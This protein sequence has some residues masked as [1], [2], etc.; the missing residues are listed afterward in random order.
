[1]SKVIKQVRARLGAKWAVALFL[2]PVAAFGVVRLGPRA[3]FVLALSVSICM[4]TSILVRAL[5]GQPWRL[6]NAGSIVTGMLLGLTLSADVPVYMILVGALVAEVVGK[7]RIDRLASNP[8]NPAA[9]GRAAI[10]V[11][12]L[13]D[14]PDYAALHVDGL[15]SAS[16]LL[17]NA[18]GNRAPE[19]WAIFVGNTPGAIGETSALLLGLSGL[20]LLA[21]VVVKREAAVAMLVTIAALTVMLPATAEIY[22]HAPWVL[23]PVVYLL[24]GPAFLYAFFFATDPATT[25]NTRWG[26]VIFGVGAGALGVLGRLYTTIPGAEMWAILIMNLAS[27]G[28]DRL[29]SRERELRKVPGGAQRAGC[30]TFY[31]QDDVGADA[32]AGMSDSLVL[33]GAEALVPSQLAPLEILR[34]ICLDPREDV[35]GRVEL[36]GLSGCGGAHFPAVRKWKTARATTGPRILI[37]NAQEGEPDSVKDRALMRQR[38]EL[39]VAGAGIVAHLIEAEEVL[40]VCGPEEVLGS[41]RLH[42]AIEELRREH[43]DLARRFKLVTGPGLYV[44]GEETA[45]IAFLEGERGEP[46]ERPPHPVESGLRGLPTVVHNAETLAWLPRLL[47][48]D[49][50]KLCDLP[51]LVTVSGDV[52]KPGVYA[53]SRDLSLVEL[54]A[55]AGGMVDGGE[56]MAYAIGGPTGEILDRDRGDMTVA[57]LPGTGTLRVLGAERCLV[58]EAL[59]ATHFA[60]AETCGRCT[61]C[62]VGS[63]EL[64][65][66]W[67]EVASGCADADVLVLID[68]LG[69]TMAETS[70]C[71]LGRDAP[72]R[73]FSV[74]RSFPDTV[75]S[76]LDGHECK[77]CKKSN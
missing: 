25:P 34:R 58:R 51:R 28:L 37:V 57:E 54:V 33:A 4:G 9:L 10:A 1:M 71:G 69:Q 73:V 66:L 48:E 12:E 18:G 11:I 13:L 29:L 42:G 2:V 45:L 74:L 70:A 59:R 16:P 8:F 43:P 55:R 68:E 31:D 52:R 50:P 21:F 65:R 20:L 32:G 56:A 44:C 67:S 41:A 27:P 6:L 15:S 14:P 53:A 60:A 77:A 3:G 62:R 23:D 22:G 36:S 46:R 61:P 17:V 49:A 26:G 38:P 30:T 75:S 64:D 35:I 63:V 40:V 76:H 39:I 72:K 7:I 47:D 19:L 24:G 5:S